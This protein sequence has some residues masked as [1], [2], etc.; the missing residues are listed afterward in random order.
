M[1]MN[2]FCNGLI[3]YP[4]L[5]SFSEEIDWL[6]DKLIKKV[7]IGRY[8]PRWPVSIEPDVLETFHRVSHFFR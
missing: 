7:G 1:A 5:C 2:I 3:P 6:Y 8:V 4:K